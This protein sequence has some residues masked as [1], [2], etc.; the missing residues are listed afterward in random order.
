M[1]IVFIPPQILSTFSKIEQTK[2]LTTTQSL[3]CHE[4][5]VRKNIYIIIY[6]LE[7]VCERET[8]DS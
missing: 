6:I 4:N 7:R 8:Q 5:F 1:T 3:A 2:I